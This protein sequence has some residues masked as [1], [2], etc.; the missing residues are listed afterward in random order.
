[1][2]LCFQL[3][4]SS[5]YMSSDGEDTNKFPGKRQLISLLSWYDYCDQVIVEAHPIVARAL[6][7][8]IKERFLVPIMEQLLL[9]SWVVWSKFWNPMQW[10]LSTLFLMNFVSK[11]LGKFNSKHYFWE[12]GFSYDKFNALAILIYQLM[13]WSCHAIYQFIN[14]SSQCSH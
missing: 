8:Q 12:I 14:F 13:N 10:F 5:L 11:M 9:Q 7:K 1:M 6:A 2:H 4:L 3:W